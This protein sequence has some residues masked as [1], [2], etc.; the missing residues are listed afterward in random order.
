MH[1]ETTVA[2]DMPTKYETKILEFEEFV[3][4]AR[5]KSCFELGHIVSMGEV[6]VTSGLVYVVRHFC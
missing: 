5:K 2:Q 3:V 6:L 1:A 4:A